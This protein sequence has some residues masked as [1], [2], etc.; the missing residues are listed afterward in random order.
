MNN[1]ITSPKPPAQTPP[2]PGESNR[3]P[4]HCVLAPSENY[5]LHLSE[6]CICVSFVSLTEPVK[7]SDLPP[8][9]ACT[10]HTADVT[11]H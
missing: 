6:H 9:A 1:F 7:K 3:K 5:D 8:V 10:A 4:P 11:H 2:A